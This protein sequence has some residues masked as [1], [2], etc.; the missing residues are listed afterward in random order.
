VNPERLQLK[1]I[2]QEVDLSH[3]APGLEGKASPLSAPDKKL[4]VTLEELGPIPMPNGGFEARFSVESISD[5]R[6]M[7]GMNC[8]ISLTE[9]KSPEPL[10]APKEAVFTEGGG[11]F[12]FV[13][14]G[15]SQPEKRAVKTGAS[16]DKTVEVLQGLSE[17]EKILLSRPK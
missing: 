8:K 7:P 10:R 15:E 11:S 1:A 6:L 3:F 12:V 4:P 9:T 5:L 13:F 14:K 16:D 2:V 17:G